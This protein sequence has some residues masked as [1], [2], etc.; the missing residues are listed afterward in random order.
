MFLDL[1]SIVFSTVSIAKHVGQ[2]FV[3]TART[4]GTQGYP[5]SLTKEGHTDLMHPGSKLIKRCPKCNIH[6]EKNED[7]A[8]MKCRSWKRTF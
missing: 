7:C 8:L 1:Y 6:I 2:T 5:V 4:L 3:Q